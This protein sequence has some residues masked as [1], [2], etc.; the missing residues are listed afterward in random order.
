[1]DKSAIQSLPSFED[2][3]TPL[4][5][6]HHPNHNEMVLILSSK[7]IC[8]SLNDIEN[9]I[10]IDDVNFPKLPIHEEEDHLSIE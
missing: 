7:E 3:A 6:S 9:C 4:K 2:L 5:R 8:R 10:S 1:M